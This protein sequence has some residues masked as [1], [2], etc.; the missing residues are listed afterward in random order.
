MIDEQ[1][2][3]IEG[4]PDYA[5]S[6]YGHVKSLRSDRILKP[7]E[8]SYGLQRVVLY[9]DREPHDFYVHHLVAAAF[10]DEYQPGMQVRHRNEQK[11][12]D[13]NVY[14][15]RFRY[16]HRMGQLVKHPT[17]PGQ[18]RRVMIIETQMIFKTVSDCANYIG[19]SPS[20][21]YR[22]LRGDRPSHL[23]YTFQYVEEAV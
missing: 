4:Y 5:I 10:L 18:I 3:A 19:G 2:A 16:G 11:K 15:L 1:W 9:K 14:N 22:V 12:S 17:P 20:S 23:G 7:R 8:N 21:I 6:N 13:N